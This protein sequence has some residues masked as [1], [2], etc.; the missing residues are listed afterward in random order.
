MYADNQDRKAYQ[1][2]YYR[3]NKTRLKR[4][5]KSYYADNKD[6][7]VI[8]MKGWREQR[9]A[10]LLAHV[11]GIKERTPCADCG[12]CFHHIA[13][14]FD[15]LPGHKKLFS[16]STMVMKTVSFERIDAE[17]AKCEV[18]CSNCHRIRTFLRN[19]AAKALRLSNG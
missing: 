15:H 8:Q 17:I 7:M 13:M 14:D 6:Q 4:Y 12:H 3:A 16:I 10:A 11:R 1:K 2:A 5:A 9:I 19:A 18:V